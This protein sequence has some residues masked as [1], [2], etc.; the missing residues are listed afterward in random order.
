[1]GV[2]ARIDPNPT[3]GP[4][5]TGP[6]FGEPVVHL[7][8]A[9]SHIEA[10]GPDEPMAHLAHRQA[11]SHRHRPGANEAL[12]PGKQQS[13]L[14]WSARGV[15]PVEHPDLLAVPRGFLEQ[16]EQ[17]RTEGVDSA[18]EVL[19]VEQENVGRVHHLAGGTAYLA[20]EAEQRNA[21][22]RIDLVRRLDH[23]VLLVALYPMLR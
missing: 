1:G 21:V 4:A 17:R 9:K 5:K 7:D 2:G 20:I 3:F 12:L 15:G 11:V 22:S 10:G 18:A 19:Q 16:V 23:V 13:P 14:D 6:G 8:D